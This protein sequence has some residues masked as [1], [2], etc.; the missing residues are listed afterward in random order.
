M[1]VEKKAGIEKLM[2][3][4]ARKDAPLEDNIWLMNALHNKCYRFASLRDSVA[5]QRTIICDLKKKVKD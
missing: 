3:L 5:R 2:E 4:L 1:E